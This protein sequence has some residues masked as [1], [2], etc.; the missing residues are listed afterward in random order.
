M[1]AELELVETELTELQKAEKVIAEA[2]QAELQA[3]LAAVNKVFEQY[4][5]CQM[6]AE[7]LVGQLGWCPADQIL[8]LPVRPSI[9]FKAG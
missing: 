8:K 5:R 6:G 2:R 4:P 1:S 9:T 7:V 3:C